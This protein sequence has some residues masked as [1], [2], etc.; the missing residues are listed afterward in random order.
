[1]N[2]NWKERFGGAAL[3][4]GA[5]GGLG[6]EF[7]RQLAAKGMNLVLVARSTDKLNALASEL[8]Q[9]HAIEAITIPLDLTRQD[10]ADILRQQ[11][12]QKGIAVGLLV[13]NAGYGSHGTLDTLDAQNEIRMV[14]LNCRTP[15]AMTHAFLPDMLSRRRGGII[16]LASVGAYQPTPYFA[17]YSATKAYNL[18]L[19]EALWAEL[20]PKGIDVIALSPGYTRTG[21]QEAGDVQSNPVG[22]WAAARDVVARCLAKLGKKPSTIYGFR[23]WFL[24]WS[25]RFTPRRLVVL[26]AKVI[27]KPTV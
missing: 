11:T 20:K 5:S 23:N 4:T 19:G 10:A 1:M 22:G 9:K 12:Q 24:A 6:A 27:S 7:A 3:I 15:L 18:M 25:L 16:F 26:L 2:N 8:R 13:N 21:F 14:D 17:N